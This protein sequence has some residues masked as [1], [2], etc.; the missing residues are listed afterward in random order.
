MQKRV[1]Q[2]GFTLV[3]LVVVIAVLAILAGVGVVAYNGY[4][5]YAHKGVDKNLVGEIK[6]AMSVGAAYDASLLDAVDEEGNPIPVGQINLYPDKGAF[7]IEGLEGSTFVDTALKDAFG[8]NYA[9]SLK[10]SWDKWQNGNGSNYF[11]SNFGKIGNTELLKGVNS[12]VTQMASFLAGVNVNESQI[13]MFYGDGAA[14]QFDELAERLGYGSKDDIFKN[15]TALANATVLF[16]AQ[17][18]DDNPDFVKKV[19]G[20]RDYILLNKQFNASDGASEI[21][22]IAYVY[23]AQYALVSYLDDPDI[24]ADFTKDIDAEDLLTKFMAEDPEAF[25]SKLIE[26]KINSDPV[27]RQRYNEYYT[28]EVSN[29][30][31]QAEIDADSF[32][33]IMSEVVK[34]QDLVLNKADMTN[35]NT[36]GPSG[37]VL[38]KMNE[39]TDS[40][41]GIVITVYS[42]GNC[43]ADPIDDES[44]TP[45]KMPEAF[46]GTVTSCPFEEEHT[47]SCSYTVQA[48]TKRIRVTSVPSSIILCN[49]E[50]EHNTCQISPSGDIPAGCVV[51]FEIS[52]GDGIVSVTSDGTLTAL[53]SGNA[54]LKINVQKD[55][56][57]GYLEIPVRI[58]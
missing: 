40:M 24:T 3:E 2:K 14:D 38:E 55:T 6:H 48:S 34:Q 28:K 4:I 41:N 8:E 50:K 46:N 7:V 19:F 53:A 23:A 36:F 26:G 13:N 12:C 49:I 52:S 56:L 20:E 35:P 31:T 32:L 54:T 57:N 9:D 22:A 43:K 27:L 15:G 42:N 5:E 16:T 10:L 39:Y 58:H 17:A 37:K 47:V 30:K 51:T 44:W 29:G 45:G 11:G 33:G 25:S 1:N 18:S 21:Y